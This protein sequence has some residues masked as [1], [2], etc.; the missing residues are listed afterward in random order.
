M[1]RAGRR[2]RSRLI[3]SSDAGRGTGVRTLS[4]DTADLDAPRGTREGAMK[5][6][7]RLVTP[8][9][10]WIIGITCFGRAT[11][12]ATPPTLVNYE[13]VLRNASNAPLNGTYDMEFRFWSSDVGGDE[14]L[15]DRHTAALGFA[16]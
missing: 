8:I 4:P 3:S 13:G 14:I 6:R 15:I 2:P 16:V 9:L 7:G 10:L 5:L 11:I 1:S 12:A